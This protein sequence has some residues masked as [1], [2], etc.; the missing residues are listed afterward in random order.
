MQIRE[1]EEGEGAFIHER[2]AKCQN[3]SFGN[4]EIESNRHVS[5]VEPKSIIETVGSSRIEVQS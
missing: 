3:I 5:K 1:I 2:E 4:V